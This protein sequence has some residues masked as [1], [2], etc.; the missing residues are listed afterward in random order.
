MPS[1]VDTTPVIRVVTETVTVRDH[2]LEQRVVAAR[3]AAAGSR[4]AGR[5]PPGP[6]RCREPRGGALD[7]QGAD[8]RHAR[9]GGLRHGR[10]ADRVAD[11]AALG[12]RAGNS[13][14]RSGCNG[15]WTSALPSSIARTTVARSTSRTRRRRKAGVVRSRVS[16]AIRRRRVPARYP[17][18]F[19]CRSAPW[20]AARSAKV[21]A[22]RSA[23]CRR[24]MRRVHLTG[25][26]YVDQWMRVVDD[27]ARGGWVFYNLVQKRPTAPTRRASLASPLFGLLGLRGSHQLQTCATHL[28]AAFA[29]GLV[30]RLVR[31]GDH[32][33][34]RS[35]HGAGTPPRRCSPSCVGWGRPPRRCGCGF[36][37]RSRALPASRFRAA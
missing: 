24:S 28:V 15:C 23:C 37:R 16:A 21:P 19:R 7:G 29:L 18:P 34:G 4:C 30:Q 10:G 6:A 22:R 32:L 9:R 36:A 31:R 35:D 12:P 33:L 27:S 2:D 11:V 5:G 3:A 26:S 25:I 20:V 13:R 8:A 17:S 14:G 1:P